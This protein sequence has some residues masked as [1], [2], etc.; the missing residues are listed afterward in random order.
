MKIKR[1]QKCTNAVMET[2]ASFLLQCLASG[3]ASQERLLKDL[4]MKCK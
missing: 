2:A 4:D 1:R 3:A